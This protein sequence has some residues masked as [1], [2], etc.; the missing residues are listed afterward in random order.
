[1]GASDEHRPPTDAELVALEA[2]YDTNQETHRLIAEVRRLRAE[3]IPAAEAL[4]RWESLTNA[5]LRTLIEHYHADKVEADEEIG[6]LRNHLDGPLCVYLVPYDGN[7]Y[8]ATLHKHLAEPL[9]RKVGAEFYHIIPL[10]QQSW[11]DVDRPVH[12]GDQ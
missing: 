6:R 8:A 2:R 12:G 5:E 4:A 9:Q 11:A 1:M 7:K 3:R 10:V